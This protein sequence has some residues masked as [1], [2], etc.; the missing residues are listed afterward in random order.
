MPASRGSRTP[1]VRL[2]V[3]GA[4][5]FGVL[6][7]ELVSTSY[8]SAD[9][10]RARIATSTGAPSTPIFWSG[11]ASAFVNFE[12]SLDGGT[13]QSLIQGLV[14]V[15]SID[16]ARGVVRI[17]G[18]DL[19]A[20]MVGTRAQDSFVNRTSSEIAT[21]IAQRHGLAPAVT[22][23]STPVGR[24]YQDEHDH[25]TPGLFC[26]GISEWDQLVFLARHEIFDVFVVGTTLFFQP[27]P[28][29]P[30]LYVLRPH[31]ALSLTLDRSLNFARD[32]EVTVKSW[33]SRLKT[34]LFQTASARGVAISD[35]PPG[36]RTGVQRYTIVQP[37]L[38]PDDASRLAQRRVSELIRHERIIEAILPGELNLNPRSQILLTGTGTDFDQVYFVQLVERSLDTRS[39]FRQRIRATNTSPRQID[40]TAIH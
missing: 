33:N 39:G 25:V 30:E 20:S 32:I 11:T 37:N 6:D 5:V 1:S 29:S 23:T 31:D 2:T 19:T 28:T 4:L 38:T 22:A 15:V 40:A 7:V 10:F 21:I 14:D 26:P 18:R 12:F 27:P 16:P 17:E 9:Q 35:S 24:Y 36:P 34:A 3:N 8:F 13:Y